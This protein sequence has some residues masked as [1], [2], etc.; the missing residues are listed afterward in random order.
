MLNSQLYQ[1]LEK[2]K[3]SGKLIIV[4]GNKDKEVLEKLGFNKVFVISGKSLEKVAEEIREGEVI[5]LTDF[6]EEGRKKFKLLKKLLESKGVKVD[7]NCRR[8]LKF[9]F[10]V[11]KIEELKFYLN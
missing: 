10:K 1:F 11:G 8:K 9:L 6:D 4:E 2:L 7:K 3:K 5:I